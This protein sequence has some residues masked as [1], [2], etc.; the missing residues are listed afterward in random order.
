MKVLQTE[1]KK[2]LQHMKVLQ[3]DQQKKP[4]EI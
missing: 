2:T 3:T 1:T 4:Y